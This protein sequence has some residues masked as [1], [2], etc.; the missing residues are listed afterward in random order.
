MLRAM[1]YTVDAR[2]LNAADYG[3]ATTRRRLFIIAVKG[4]NRLIRW[5]DPTHAPST[6]LLPGLKPWRAA[7]E[8]IDWSVPGESIF[9]RKR[10]LARST[11]ERIFLGLKKFGGPEL[12]AYL[13]IPR[14]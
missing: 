1:G 10:K 9:T 12:A 8:I 11:L 5:P 13:V 6:S 2:V 4:M 3:G 14:P 7:R